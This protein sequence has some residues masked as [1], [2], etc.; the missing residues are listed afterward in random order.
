[1]TNSDNIVEAHITFIK[2][3]KNLA[4]NKVFVLDTNKKPLN[5]VHPGYARRLLKQGKAAVFRR[6]PFTIILKHPVDKAPEPLRIKIDSGS[7]KTGIAILNDAEG[8]VVFAAEIEHRGELIKARLKDRRDVR[9]NRRKR[10]TRYRPPR[11]LNRRRKEGWLPPSLLSRVFNIETWV[12]SFMRIAPIQAISLELAK[13]DTQKMGDP[14]IS[15]VE[16][17]KG[18]LAGFEAWEYLLEK[19]GRRCA[20]CGKDDVPLE[21]DHIVSRSRGGSDRVSN[22]IVSCRKCNQRKGDKLVEEFLKNKPKVLERI[23]SQVKAPLRD[24]AAIHST[25]WT[26][27]NKLKE[28]GLPLEIGSGGL[29]KFNRTQRGLPKAHWLDA[30]CVGY[31]TPEKLKVDEINPLQIK[32]TG[33]GNRQM[34][35]VNRFGF[36]RSRAK[37]SKIVHGFQTG[38]MVRAEVPDGKKA[39]VHVGCVAIKSSGYFKI[40]TSHGKVDG[41]NHEYCRLLHRVDGYQYSSS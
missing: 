31:S 11:F 17:Q 20:Y 33:H 22:L 19:W 7:K 39:G 38:D 13:F 15:G 29:T 34:C 25:R 16:Y 6:Y 1:M 41:V 2:E 18:T 37:Q 30:A 24:V 23:K 9:R 12:R 36:P 3:A 35:L 8:E 4:T 21:K 40:N 27:F 5:P 26:I 32:A 14:E 10:K 28:F